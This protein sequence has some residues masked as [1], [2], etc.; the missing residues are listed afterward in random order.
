MFGG[1]CFKGFQIRSL[2]LSVPKIVP[3]LSACYSATFR[4]ILMA[5]G[6]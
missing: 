6:S 2:A 5:T 4:C 3:V 1:F